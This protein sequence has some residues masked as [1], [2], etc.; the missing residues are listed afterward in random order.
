MRRGA[1][2]TGLNIRSAWRLQEGPPPAE[3]SEGHVSPPKRARGR[4]RAPSRAPAASPPAAA[5]EGA[6]TPASRGRPR[7]PARAPVTGAAAAAA[8]AAG[9]AA[10]A[11]PCARPGAPAAAPPADPLAALPRAQLAELAARFTCATQDLQLLGLLRPAAR[12]RGQWAQRLVFPPPPAAPDEAGH[13]G[14]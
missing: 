1:R 6:A 4:P 14:G 3:A 9:A 2:S 10:A 13:T 11:A 5:P 8:A 7:A 12:R